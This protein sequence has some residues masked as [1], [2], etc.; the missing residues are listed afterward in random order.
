[1]AVTQVEGEPVLT[2]NS[3]F[4]YGFVSIISL[5]HSESASSLPYTAISSIVWVLIITR[6]GA[7]PNWTADPVENQNLEKSWD[8][9]KRIFL[10][11]QSASTKNG[12]GRKT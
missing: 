4:H 8:M 9:Q 11:I 2:Q 1:M 12:R 5:S 3:S 10:P 6:L 7:V